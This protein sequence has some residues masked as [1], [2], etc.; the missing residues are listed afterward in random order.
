MKTLDPAQ[1]Q[2]AIAL[3]LV[4]SGRHP[5]KTVADTLGMARS[6]LAV[7]AEPAK[8]P[9]R[10][11][12]PPRPD[13][14]LLAEIKAVI[15][16]LPSYG[17]RRVHALVRRQREQTGEPAV[18]V[19]RIYRVMKPH[20]LRLQRHSGAGIERRHDGR[21]AVDQSDTRWCSDGFEIG[22]G[23]GERVRVAFTL[24]CCDAKA[25]VPDRSELHSVLQSLLVKVIIEWKHNRLR[26]VWK[27]G[28]ESFVKVDMQPQRKVANKR[29][30]DGPRFLPGQMARTCPIFGR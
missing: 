18:N 6:N 7:Q 12:R 30:A 20:G 8:I 26:F 25:P 2:K 11:G 21:V 19:K 1:P 4:R 29:R 17:Y 16:D 15:A 14:A 22:C 10:G 24:D 5:M 27:H 13:A 23:N 9:R 28:R 3:V